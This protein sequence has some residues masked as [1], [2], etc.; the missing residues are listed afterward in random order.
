MA[1]LGEEYPRMQAH[2]RELLGIYKALPDGVGAFGAMVI[3][4]V[5]QRACEAAASGDVV[6]MTRS[7]EEMKECE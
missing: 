7:F 5:L 2:V 4:Q 6:A 3:E 1:S